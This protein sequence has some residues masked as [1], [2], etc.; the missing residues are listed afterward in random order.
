MRGHIEGLFINVAM[1]QLGVLFKPPSKIS[2]KNSQIK[3]I[4]T[5]KQSAS[6]LNQ[7]K[8]PGVPSVDIVNS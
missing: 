6:A 3:I 4:M 2:K 7:V 1:A 5:I 8:I